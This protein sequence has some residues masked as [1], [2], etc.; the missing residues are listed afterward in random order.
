MTA[1]IPCN[2]IPVTA[3]IINNDKESLFHH[4]SQPHAKTEFALWYAQF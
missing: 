3:K 2:N 4:G 1:L